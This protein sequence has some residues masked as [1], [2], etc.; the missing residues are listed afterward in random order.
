MNG[1]PMQQSSQIR[2]GT[3][4]PE[5]LAP[6]GSPEAFRAAVA[7]GADAVYLGGKQFG[8]RRSAPNFTD[9][10]I[11]EAITYAH[12]RDVRVYVTI[13]T[14]IHDRELEH[15]AEYLI[16]LYSVGADAVLIQDTGVAAL[17]RNIVPLLPLHAST[18]M[19]LHTTD[20][21]RWAAEQGF[22]RVVLARELTLEEISRIARET[23]K[24][25][26]GLEVFAHG[27]LCYS[28]SGQCL[29]SSVIG[30]RSGNRGMCAQPCRKPYS[31][32]TAETDEYG[33]PTGIR[34]VP[35]PGHFLLSPKDLCTYANLPDLVRSPVV[36]LKIEGRMKSAEYVSIVVST[37]RKALD[38]IASGDARVP[39]G[40]VQDLL[41]AFNRGFTSGYLFGQ[42]HTTLMGR[43]AGDNRGICIGVVKRYDEQSKTITIRSVGGMIPSP[44]DGLLIIHPE[45]NRESGFSLNTAPLQKK[46]EIVLRV[47]HPV[48]SGARVYITSSTDLDRRSRQI[49]AHP[50]SI[51]LR[52][53]PVDLAASVDADGRLVLEGVIHTRNGQE[54][55]VTCRSDFS[56]APAQTRPVT[57]DQLSRQLIKTG[58]S[59]FSLRNF[60]LSYNGDMFAPL[61]SLNHARREFLILA[62]ETLAGCIPPHNI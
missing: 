60:T 43:D 30:G 10:E 31:L 20:G 1:T 56:M 37:Y 59:P 3:S 61:A 23:G 50:P 2:N 41:L 5:L 11:E 19:T 16:W 36:S 6:A 49:T 38:A 46:G 53:V 29:L 55:P 42:R 13:N 25:G 22:S 39:A 44:G 58:G 47:P 57:R 33:R 24:Y 40:A 32:V 15:V 8:A 26:I 9:A 45:T 35:T 54:I 34:K 51:L 14:L 21:V 18:Q 12:R 17:A 28:Y 7:A 52:P 4:L 27:A 62:E 48:E